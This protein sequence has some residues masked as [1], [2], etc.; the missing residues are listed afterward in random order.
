[1]E[2]GAYPSFVAVFTIR[3]IITVVPSI[4]PG[5]YNDEPGLFFDCLFPFY[6][7]SKSIVIP[8][9]E[10][11]IYYPAAAYNI[12]WAATYMDEGYKAPAFLV[13]LAS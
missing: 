13:W 8:V 5:F 4:F 1:M 11:S 7:F 6:F 3:Y 9:Q 12:F 10:I 2:T